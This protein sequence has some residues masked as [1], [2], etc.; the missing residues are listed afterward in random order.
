MEWFDSSGVGL[1]D[2]EES[3]GKRYST[4]LGSQFRVARG[5]KCA[6]PPESGTLPAT[7]P[8]EHRISPLNLPFLRCWLLCQSA[9]LMNALILR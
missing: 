7:M 3:F 1:H 8:N 6:T 5:Y 4:P 2:N 9:N